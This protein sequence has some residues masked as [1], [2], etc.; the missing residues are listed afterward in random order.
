MTEQRCL[1][2]GL[3]CHHICF[4]DVSTPVFVLRLSKLFFSFSLQEMYT[5]KWMFGLLLV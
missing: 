4:M 5:D 2:Y 1:V 3:M